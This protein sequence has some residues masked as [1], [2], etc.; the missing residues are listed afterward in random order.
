MAPSPQM[1]LLIAHVVRNPNTGV[2]AVISSLARTQRTDGHDVALL[3]LKSDAWNSPRIIRELAQDIVWS[4]NV[5]GTA[6]FFYHMVAGASDPP[7]RH[8]LADES[9][10]LVLH[11]LRLTHR[12]VRVKPVTVSYRL[13]LTGRYSFRV[14]AGVSRWKLSSRPAL[15]PEERARGS[16][17]PD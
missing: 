16:E 7:A 13:P 6:A 14:S 5:F 15:T 9:L 10:P 12:C 8:V 11:Y 17:D 1:T 4:S 2:A 3:V